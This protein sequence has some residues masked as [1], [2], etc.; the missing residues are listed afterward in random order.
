METIVRFLAVFFIFTF[1][2]SLPLET[3]PDADPKIWRKVNF[4]S[5]IA[6]TLICLFSLLF[7]GVSEMNFSSLLI[8]LTAMWLFYVI[9][10]LRLRTGIDLWELI[11]SVLTYY[12]IKKNIKD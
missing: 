10:I 2:I 1:A 12:M 7:P 4:S 5:L 6:F 3:Y 11:T 9:D 8:A